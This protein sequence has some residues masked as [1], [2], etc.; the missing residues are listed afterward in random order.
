[1]KKY[2]KKLKSKEEAKRPGG[3]R[4]GHGE[5]YNPGE[6]LALQYCKAHLGP[7]GE[8]EITRY[9]RTLL[10]KLKTARSKN[11]EIPEMKDVLEH[12]KIS[13]IEKDYAQLKLLYNIFTFQSNLAKHNKDAD[14]FRTSLIHANGYLFAMAHIDKTN[15][16]P[17]YTDPTKKKNLLKVWLDGV[18][19]GHPMEEKEE[20]DIFKTMRQLGLPREP[21]RYIL[22]SYI[23][24]LK[25]W[26][27]K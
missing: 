16:N 15:Q 7:Y 8:L 17:L 21:D 22:S 6:D 23:D 25:R 18:P 26:G 24:D 2:L 12:I 20:K 10:D 1:M 19:A 11:E 3:R 14:H 13:I 5:K 9:V 27:W 4:K